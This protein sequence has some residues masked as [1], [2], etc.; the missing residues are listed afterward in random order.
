[1]YLNQI[2]VLILVTDYNALQ[3]RH[4]IHAKHTKIKLCKN[5]LTSSVPW[6][7]TGL[8]LRVQRSAVSV[9]SQTATNAYYF[10]CYSLF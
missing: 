1:M 3:T 7:S 5:I 4:T 10:H 9:L 2:K 8:V 6:N